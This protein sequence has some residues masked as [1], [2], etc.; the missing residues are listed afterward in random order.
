MDEKDRRLRELEL[1]AKIR[2]LALREAELRQRDSLQSAEGDAP[3]ETVAREPGSK[4][5]SLL[6]FALKQV[7]NL[8]Y[9]LSS[10]ILSALVGAL[11]TSP[12]SGFVVGLALSTVIA[13]TAIGFILH[14]AVWNEENI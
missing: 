12:P 2:E 8:L 4:G 9:G 10:I 6:T 3:G 14:L 7:R 13:L 5:S 11:F 1:E